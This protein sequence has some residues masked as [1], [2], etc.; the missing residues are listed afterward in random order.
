M[1]PANLTDPIYT[2]AEKAR[3][4]LESVR[5][6][7][8][9][10]CP[11]CGVVN[12]ATLMNGKSHRAGLYQCKECEKQFSVMVGT[13]YERSHIPLNKWL[14]AT[15]LICSSKKGISAHQLFRNLGFGSYRT[16]W[17]MAMR[18][19]EGMAPKKGPIAPLGGEGK[20]LEAD[21]T[22]IGG[23]E[24]NK[25]LNKRDP[26]NIGGAGKMIV[27]TL[28]ERDGAARSHHIAN[29]TGRTLRPILDAHAHRASAFFTDTAGGYMH[30]GKEFSRHEMV[31]HGAGEYVRD[32]AHS[33]TAE[34]YFAILKR[35]VYGTFHHVSEAHLHRYLA[36][37]D[38]RYSNRIALGI[39]DAQ[40]AN[41]ALKGIEGKRLMYKSPNGHQA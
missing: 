33:N 18:I 9:P 25:H 28:V 13:L 12:S 14:L 37:F 29:V 31:D 15:H 8:G 5:W 2:D 35:G 7:E 23:K 40:R 6:P 4:Y 22:Y 32:D 38:F 21:T 19:R 17:F 11:H 27:H 10:V 24:K 3:E 34:G 1:L 16:A 26:R 41:T 20:A 36:E 30:V 39:D